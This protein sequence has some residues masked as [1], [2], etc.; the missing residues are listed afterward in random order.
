MCGTWTCVLTLV[1]SAFCAQAQEG[2]PGRISGSQPTPTHP[3]SMAA[4]TARGFTTK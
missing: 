1:I 2:N 3:Y 4:C